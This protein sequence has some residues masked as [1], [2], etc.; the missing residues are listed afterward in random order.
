MGPVCQSKKKQKRN[1]NSNLEGLKTT[2][3]LHIVERCQNLNVAF[4]ALGELA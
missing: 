2:D 4:E 3:C 1:T